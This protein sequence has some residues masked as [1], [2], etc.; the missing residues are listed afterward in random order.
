MKL[1]RE[2]R[3]YNF[4][5]FG[6]DL[7]ETVNNT[8]DEYIWNLLRDYAF[9][10]DFKPNLI[11]DLHQ[12]YGIDKYELF[13]EISHKLGVELDDFETFKKIEIVRDLV[14]FMRGLGSG[15]SD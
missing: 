5:N 2:R 10:R 11:D 14:L 1:N 6:N 3:G 15:R 9:V 13:L 12:L 7:Q 8:C 4:E